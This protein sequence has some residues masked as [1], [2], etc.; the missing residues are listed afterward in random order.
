LIFEG[1]RDLLARSHAA[2]TRISPPQFDDGG[3][4]FRGD[5]GRGSYYQGDPGLFSFIGKAARGIVSISA[6]WNPFG[7]WS[8]TSKIVIAWGA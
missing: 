8:A 2:E 7:S 4:A 3:D 1:M 6:S 5:Y